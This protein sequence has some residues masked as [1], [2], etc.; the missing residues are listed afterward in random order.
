MRRMGGM[1]N[2]M[3]TRRGFMAAGASRPLAV[4]GPAGPLAAQGAAGARRSVA[5]M[6]A[7]DPDLVAYRRAVAAMKALPLSDPRNWTRF[8]LVHRD[9]CPHG[10]W[11]FLPWHRAYL[12]SFERVC[13]E[14]SGK[15]DFALPYWDWTANRR[16]PQAFTAG[17]PQSNPL[18]NPRPGANTALP[19]DMV[20]RA[21]ITRILNSP[22]FEAFGSTRPRGQDSTGSQWQRRMGSK[23]E[24]EFNPHDGVHTTVGGDMGVVARA[25]RDPIFYLHHANL[26]R[27]WSAWNGRGNGN[28]PEANWRN[29][30]FEGNFINPDGSP[31]NVAVGDLQSTPALGY[32]Y[33]GE[34]GP[35][36]ADIDLSWA[37]GDPLTNHLLAYRRLSQ[38]TLL[39]PTRQLRRI[40]LPL[41]EA[42]YVGVVENDALASRERPVSIPVPLGRPLGRIH[43]SGCAGCRARS[44]AAEEARAASNA[45]MRLG[46]HARHRAAERSE[47]SR[48][49][50]RQLQ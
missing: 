18:N 8:S 23:T 20:G 43:Q 1:G 15:A 19:D 12:V 50:L 31:W 48:A 7:N 2:R 10:N 5:T 26:D 39:R 29:F 27:L 13:R 34:D 49:H 25:A 22:D 47:H 33:E 46:D 36:A 11:Y 37:Q 17:T 3:L 9:F 6:A 4:L 40:A 28:S 24:L 32:R 42:L 16:V 21:V 44:R 30:T 45:A 41:G 14:L 35:F 38:D